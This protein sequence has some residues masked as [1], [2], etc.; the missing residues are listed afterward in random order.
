MSEYVQVPNFEETKCRTTVECF[1]IGALKRFRVSRIAPNAF[2]MV[3]A[4]AIVASVWRCLGL[5]VSGLGF[6]VEELTQGSCY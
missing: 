3:F 5:R 1:K 6:R 4:V 2:L